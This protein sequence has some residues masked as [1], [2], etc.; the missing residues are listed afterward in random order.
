MEHLDD[1]NFKILFFSLE[2]NIV[3]LY[4]KLLSIYIFETYGIQLTFKEILSRK[5]DYV[6]SNEHYDL[7]VECLP[8]ID[9]ISKKL[10]IY[11][12][13]VSAN[14]VYAILKKR[15]EEIGT[16]KETDT[17]MIYVPNN[18]NLIYN[19]VIDHIG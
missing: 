14:T 18:P 13:S 1:D 3:S 11:D 15:L 16:F 12:K 7:I 19:V 5:K 9:K 4:I 8:W 2:M 10:E 17:R 6:L